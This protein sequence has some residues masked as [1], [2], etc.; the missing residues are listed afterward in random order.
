M[1]GDMS[2]LRKIADIRSDLVEDGVLM[3]DEASEVLTRLEQAE[4]SARLV[5]DMLRAVL[6]AFGSGPETDPIIKA[7]QIV[8]RLEQAEQAVQRVREMHS[9]IPVKVNFDE[10]TTD[11]CDFCGD[12]EYPC[13]TI[14]ALDG[15]T[16]E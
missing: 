9:V 5:D 4:D 6:E 15:E 10:F 11:Y 2:E 8:A 7:R 12:L 3:Y 13:P 16:H 14:R 1:S